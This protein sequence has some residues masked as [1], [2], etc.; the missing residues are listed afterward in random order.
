MTKKKVMIVCGWWDK[1]AHYFCKVSGKKFE[2]FNVRL[3]DKTN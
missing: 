2:F 3:T 1:G